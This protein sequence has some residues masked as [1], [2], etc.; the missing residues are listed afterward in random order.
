M[1]NTGSKTRLARIAALMACTLGLIAAAQ[2]D[3]RRFR[4]HEFRE[5]EFRERAFLDARYHHNHYYPPPGFVFGALPGGHRVVVFGGMEYFFAGG[6][7]YRHAG[8]HFLVVAPP[9]GI[10][11]PVLPPYCTTILVGGVP[12]YYANSV[13]YVQTPQGYVVTQ[14]PP[15]N[16][17]VEQPPVDTMPGNGVVELGPVSNPPPAP[18]PGG[19]PGAGQLFAYPRQGQSPDQQAKDQYECRGWASS[20]T[21]F[22]PNVAGQQSQKLPDYQRAMGAC[23]EARGYTVK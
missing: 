1:F 19:V 14:P 4:E 9:F 20:Q 23:L 15:A 10:V 7:W 8:E 11:V 5:H 22:D 21:G 6:V 17:V 3:E 16:V 12:Y 18:A 2:A 13:Y